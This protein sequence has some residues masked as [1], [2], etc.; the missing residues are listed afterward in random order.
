MR[1]VGPRTFAAVQWSLARR[2]YRDSLLTQERP[3]VGALA[4]ARQGAPLKYFFLDTCIYVACSLINKEGAHPDLLVALFE[5]LKRNDAKLLLPDAVLH[6]YRRK[7]DIELAKLAKDIDGFAASGKNLAAAED[8]RKLNDFFEQLKGE[9]KQAAELAREFV[10][11]LPEER[12]W[13]VGMPLTPEIVTA[14]VVTSLR[15]AKPSWRSRAVG[16]DSRAAERGLLEVD[17]LIV[18][19]LA[20]WANRVRLSKDDVILFCSDNHK[21]FAHFD[22]SEDRHVIDP[23]I[24]ALF[25]CPL[26]FHLRLGDMLR[27]ELGH[28]VSPPDRVD[29]MEKALGA[30]RRD[31]DAMALVDRRSTLDQERHHAEAMREQLLGAVAGLRSVRDILTAKDEEGTEVAEEIAVLSRQL[32]DVEAQLARLRSEEAEVN[33]ALHH[34]FGDPIWRQTYLTPEMGDSQGSLEDLPIPS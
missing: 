29:E 6:E 32:N 8:K 27:A 14:A 7:V 31:K 13:V 22:H 34:P 26:E 20:E 5:N 11:R 1:S 17:C 18:S 10:E 33:R 21:D 12:G 16:D 4:P 25:P 15:G 3:E 24:Q 28:D 30:M 19:T 2:T 9:R 23:A